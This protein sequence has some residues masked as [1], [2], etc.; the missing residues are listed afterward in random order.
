M[1]EIPAWIEGVLQPVD[2]LEVHRRG[3]RHKAVSVF[4][5]CGAET[6]IQRRAM[7]KYHTPGLWANAC[8][9]HP[10]WGET[11]EACA[12]RRLGE[13]LG[14]RDVEVTPASTVE[15]R[16]EVGGG[17]V[18]H[19]LV[20]VFTAILPAP[21]RLAPD[22][23]EVMATAWIGSEHLRERVRQEPGAFAPWLRIYLERNVVPAMA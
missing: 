21:V 17:L 3:L 7:G 1:A 18:E 23:D 11:G 22:P 8:C 19:E 10:D 4:L 2:K 20:E 14:L 16:A 15:Y 13:E 5:F 6:L 9:S 12:V